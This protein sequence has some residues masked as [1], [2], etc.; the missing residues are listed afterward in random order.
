MSMGSEMLNMKKALEMAS[1]LV[2]GT[3]AISKRWTGIKVSQ[4]AVLQS[5]I[6]CHSNCSGREI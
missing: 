5:W 1:V 6:H 2:W 4:K 3:C